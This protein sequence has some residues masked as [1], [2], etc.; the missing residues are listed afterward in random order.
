MIHTFS[1][2][3][4]RFLSHRPRAHVAHRAPKN[5]QFFL[6]NLDRKSTTLTLHINFPFLHFSPN[7]QFLSAEATRVHSYHSANIRLIKNCQYIVFNL[8]YVGHNVERKLLH[9]SGRVSSVKNCI[10]VNISCQVLS[11]FLNE[12]V[13]NI[14]KRNY[15]IT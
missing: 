6:V 1:E 5:K 2:N 11:R 3:S 14:D 15:D 9:L 4:E 13:T 10:V 7:G 8:R 12:N